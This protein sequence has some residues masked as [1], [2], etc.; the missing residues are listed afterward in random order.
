MKLVLDFLLIA[1]F[2]LTAI[3]IIFLCRRKE[4]EVSHNILIV[5]FSWISL[6]FL[7][8]YAYLHQI[9]FLFYVTFPFSNSI[10]VFIGPLFWLYVQGV[11]GTFRNGA[12]AILPHFAFPILYWIGI[13][14]PVLVGML[15]DGYEI[16]YLDH[17]F[18][19]VL[20]TIS[21]S[22]GYC[23]FTFFRLKHFQQ[24]MKRQYSNLENKNLDW[25]KRLLVGTMLIMTISLITSV[26]ETIV[27]DQ[28]WDIDFLTVIPITFLVAYTGYYGI[29]Q[30]SVLLPDFLRASE[31][32][33]FSNRAAA[34]KSKVL[35]YQYDI[36]DMENLEETL[37]QVMESEKPFLDENLTLT[38]LA[39]M[40]QVSD[41]KLSTLLNQNMGI[42]FYDYINGY[43]VEEVKKTLLLPDSEKFTLLAI[44]YDC[45]FKS[46]SSFN[47][48]FKKIEK[49][50]PS[51]YR[52]S[53]LPA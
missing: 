10:D 31:H 44:A 35:R 6:V 32:N 47:R 29:S 46:K 20:F 1:G 5:I 17:L 43:R 51:E 11:S 25:I 18:P 45:G 52:K 40:L 37:N 14:L 53:I 33:E 3:I 50:S 19:Y 2:L 41:K 48:I 21:Y 34:L 42:S 15:F 4:K 13:T 28:G 49:R 12:K 30:S 9:P 16:S 22:L 8:Y 27:G 23:L 38:I 7:S 24:L 26:Y 39:R 36:K